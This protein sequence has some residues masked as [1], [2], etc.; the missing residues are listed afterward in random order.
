MIHSDRK[1][2]VFVAVSCMILALFGFAWKQRTSIPFVTVPLEEI[3][4][5]FVYGSARVLNNITTGIGVIDTAIIGAFTDSEKDNTIATLE[6]KLANQDEVVAE[7]IRYRQLLNYKESHPEFTMTVAGVI[8]KGY[9]TWTNTFTIDRG[10]VDG[11]EPNMAVVVPSGVV[12]FIT[13][14][15][16]HSARVQTFLDPRSAIGVIIQRPE[17]RLAGVVK[18]DGNRP[19]EPIMVNIARDGDVLVGDKLITSGYGGIYP[20]GLL[21]GNVTNI[22]NDREGFVKNATIKPTVDFHRLEEVFIITS[23]TVQS[24]EKAPLEPRLVPQTQR[25]QVQGVKGAVAP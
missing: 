8:T 5:P 17:S 20:K 16:P 13:D 22:E 11:I 10:E 2:I 15:Y 23:S 6:Q 25:D 12:G 19:N 24:P 14:V 18:G 21:V 7:N 9:G 1:L 4:T 3:T